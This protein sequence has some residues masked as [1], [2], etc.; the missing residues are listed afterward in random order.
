MHNH[1]LYPMPEELNALLAALVELTYG[2]SLLLLFD[3][4]S[5]V[6]LDYFLGT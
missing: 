2:K 4:I 1:N 5:S 3:L 6:L